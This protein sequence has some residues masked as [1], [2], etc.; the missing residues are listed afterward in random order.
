VNKDIHQKIVEAADITTSD[1]VLEI[2]SGLGFLTE[3]LL[4]TKCKVTAIEI[5]KKLAQITQ[6]RLPTTNRLRVIHGDA[7]NIPFPKTITKVVS[8]LPYSSVSSLLRR[9]LTEGHWS[10]AVLLVQQEI[11]EKLQAPPGN[12]QYHYLSVLARLHS[13]MEVLFRVPPKF[14]LPKPEVTSSVIRFTSKI[15]EIAKVDLPLFYEVTRKLFLYRRKIAR[16]ALKYA[17]R[18]L[19]KSKITAKELLNHS[20]N[21]KRIF[22]LKIP[23]LEA[24][25]TWVKQQEGDDL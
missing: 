7:I 17:F 13:S 16:S 19:F 4:Q 21:N 9:I 3:I 2:G 14:F 15:P 5:D 12:R 23:E 10:I 8:N 11:A 1:H 22:Q 25:T 20:W 24:I 6:E 18:N